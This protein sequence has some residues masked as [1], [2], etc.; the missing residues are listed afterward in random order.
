M[1]SSHYNSSSRGFSPLSQHAFNLAA[2]RTPN[3]FT[4]G[5]GF[6]ASLHPNYQGQHSDSLEC[7][8]PS[9]EYT[10]NLANPL[11]AISDNYSK[12]P[13]SRN[14][15]TAR[16]CN[17]G[18]EYYHNAKLLNSVSSVNDSH[19][20]H[21]EYRSDDRNQSHHNNN[22]DYKLNN[23]YQYH[24]NTSATTVNNNNSRLSNYDRA[25]SES[26][27]TQRGD[28]SR[29]YPASQKSE[30]SDYTQLNQTHRNSEHLSNDTN[31]RKSTTMLDHHKL[32][33]SFLGP[34]LAALHSMTEMK[35]ANNNNSPNNPNHSMQQTQS[36]L[37][38]HGSNPHGIDTI[39]SRPT[40]VTTA[41]LNA[42]TNG[43]FQSMAFSHF[44]Q[45]LWIFL[46]SL[47]RFS[48]IYL[49]F[50]VV[51]TKIDNFLIEYLIGL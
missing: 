22:N 5:L 20:A 33:L 15:P 9:S 48:R 42:L 18:S 27:D 37:N 28:S 17:S 47:G 3:F 45:F 6:G 7:H 41:G 32:P 10:N 29:S 49:H 4:H 24:Q 1:L 16:E 12:S 36:P 51:V 14:C 39:L 31:T 11:P 23:N 2:F 30:E 44:N 35:S 46:P 19:T 40:P 50:L 13:T 43:T 34:P 38:S 21:G 25:S 26:P 8:S